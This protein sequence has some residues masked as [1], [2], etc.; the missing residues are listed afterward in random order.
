MARRRNVGATANAGEDQRASQ[1]CATPLSLNQG[2]TRMEAGIEPRQL[3]DF[4]ESCSPMVE[5]PRPL[6]IREALGTVVEPAVSRFFWSRP[7][8]TES[9]W[10]ENSAS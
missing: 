10:A 7:A 1:C 6:G 2:L 8:S 9:R 4:G 3:R 5:Q